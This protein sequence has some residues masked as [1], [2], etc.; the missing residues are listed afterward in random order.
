MMG[1]PVLKDGILKVYT[2]ETNKQGSGCWLEVPLM[3][4]WT[5]APWWL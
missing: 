1:K 5:I 2:E 3:K 4:A